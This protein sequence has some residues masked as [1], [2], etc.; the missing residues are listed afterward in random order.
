MPLKC[1]DSSDESKSYILSGSFWSLIANIWIWYMLISKYQ[2]LANGLSFYAMACLRRQRQFNNNNATNNK[3]S[4]AT[5]YD[6]KN[7]KQTPW[8]VDNSK[9]C[10]F[11]VMLY[12]SHHNKAVVEKN[13][14]KHVYNIRSRRAEKKVANKHT[15]LSFFLKLFSRTKTEL[16]RI[17]CCLARQSCSCRLWNF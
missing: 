16:T 6:M 13:S 9:Q 11:N 15:K 4:K 7:I 2:C 17:F 1:Y 12:I 3:R 10:L 14:S 8:T 5:T